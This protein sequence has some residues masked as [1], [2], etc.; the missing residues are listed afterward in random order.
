MNPILMGPILTSWW[1]G[2]WVSVAIELIFI[3]L[4][5]GIWLWTSRKR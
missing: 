2:P 3:L 5:G 4:V 1:L